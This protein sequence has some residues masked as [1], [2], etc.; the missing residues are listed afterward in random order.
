[1]I[2]DLGAYRVFPAVHI[3]F[4]ILSKKERVIM[5]VIW[6]CVVSYLVALS[7]QEEQKQQHESDEHAWEEVRQVQEIT[8]E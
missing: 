4:R 8:S 5:W 2:S 3:L 7:L 6:V 1:M